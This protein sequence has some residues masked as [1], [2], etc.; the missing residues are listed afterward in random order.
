MAGFEI[1]RGKQMKAL[2]VL[3]Y[4]VEGV[5]KTTLAA[6][7]PDP[8]FIDCEGGTDSYDVARFPAPTSWEM[9]MQEVQQVIDNPAMCST[10]VIDTIDWAEAKAIESVCRKHQVENIE[11]FGWSKGYTYLNEEIGKLLNKLSEVVNK[12][13]NVVLTAHMAV[14]TITLPDDA[15]AYDRYELKLKTAKNGNNSQLVKEWAD[16]VLF[17][18]YRQFVV[19]DEKTKKNKATGGKERVMYTSRTSAYDA[20]NRFGLP[21]QLPQS[22][23]AICHPARSFLYQTC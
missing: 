22:E 18:N 14:R 9:L 21:D 20:K 15:G 1:T 12:G 3:V 8:V 6:S 17:C 2:K 13:V 16:M 23:P 10:L 4:G 5:G 19:E 7:F 11:D